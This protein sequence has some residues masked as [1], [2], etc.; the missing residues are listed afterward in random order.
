MKQLFR[1]YA[2]G[3]PAVGLVAVCLAF[4]T[5][6]PAFSQ[7]EPLPPLD[8]GA[9]EA[10]MPAPAPPSDFDNDPSLELEPP[11]DRSPRNGVAGD[12]NEAAVEGDQAVTNV[13]R[14]HWVH[15]TPGGE[16]R[17]RISTINDETEQLEPAAGLQI[18]FI[19]D[20]Q[21]RGQADTLPNGEFI[22]SGLK[23]G[24]YTL[25]A[26][27]ARGFVAYSLNLLPAVA[28]PAEV[29]RIR[30]RGN[31]DPI[32][33]VQ[34]E[35]AQA[36]LAIDT[37]AIPPTFL[38]LKAIVRDYY[39]EFAEGVVRED[40][41]TKAAQVD[42]QENRPGIEDDTG[43]ER[44]RGTDQLFKKLPTAKDATSI[45]HHQIPLTPDGRMIGRLYGVDQAS[46]RP[47]MIEDVN[48]FIIQDDRIAAQLRVDKYGIF[49]AKGLEPGGYSIVAAGR[50]G[51]G[52]VGFQLVVGAPEPL[53]GR[54]ST[55]DDMILTV[56]RRRSDR[57]IRPVQA[58]AG[59]FAPFPFAMG[60]IDDPRDIQAAFSAMPP[61]PAL[62][63]D[64]VPAEM[65]ASPAPLGGS[66]GG[67]G[68][69][70]GTAASGG[71]GGGGS[72]IGSLL[73]L[74]GLGGLAALED[75]NDPPA[76]VSPFGPNP[77]PQQ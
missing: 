7:V 44:R 22:A 1:E 76:V 24:V 60:L 25:V 32:R 2:L 58:Q 15:L 26:S 4:A 42:Q 35:V 21:T 70:S 14:A 34:F 33:L 23:P 73:G 37:A 48:V 52:A 9:A 55:T 56:Y 67:M 5:P 71:M 10:G 20:G 41:F 50:D 65:M 12:W 16:V 27:G 43:A 46:G 53:Q 54:R 49:A 19:Q 18:R 29:G 45:R 51:F 62:A 66:P 74:A 28:P 17:G 68:G 77:P 40:E 39:R 69:P 63:M 36:E 57:L 3:I 38:T 6:F 13:I 59:G 31:R 72:G 61:M 8:E 47:R 11:V 64:G 30:T 75:D